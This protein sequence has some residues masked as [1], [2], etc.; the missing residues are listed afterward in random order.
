[1]QSKESDLH[2]NVKDSI[3]SQDKDEIY[4]EKGTEFHMKESAY[5]PLQSVAD[6]GA[7]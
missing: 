4:R 3:D 7:R 5:L 6:S 1:M 2:G